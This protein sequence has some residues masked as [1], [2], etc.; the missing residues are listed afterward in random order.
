MLLVNQLRFKA[1]AVFVALALAMLIVMIPTGTAQAKRSEWGAQTWYAPDRG[2]YYLNTSWA[3]S[4]LR[5]ENSIFF[6][7]RDTYEHDFH[8]ESQD[9]AKFTGHWSSNL[10]D[11]V[12]DV[13]DNI[14]FSNHDSF[15]I[16][17]N[18]PELIQLNKEYWVYMDLTRENNPHVPHADYQLEAEFHDWPRLTLWI[19]VLA[20]GVTPDQGGWNPN[21]AG[22]KNTPLALNSLVTPENKLRNPVQEKQ[23]GLIE[24][25]IQ[26]VRPLTLAEASQLLERYKINPLAVRYVASDRSFTGGLSFEHDLRTSFSKAIK[27]LATDLDLAKELIKQEPNNQILAHMLNTQKKVLT[28]L[29]NQSFEIQGLSVVVTA[30]KLTE[31]QR[32]TQITVDII[33]ATP[34]K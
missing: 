22:I 14:W 28:T 6:D 16:R 21:V 1:L 8:I 32:D 18:A 11:P 27:G 12:E 33:D 15:A 17:S 10:P 29:K 23:A 5:W 3:Y 25:E 20:W 2:Q 7:N 34:K 4:T 13:E 9:F 31:L 24:A 30:D 26:F 19:D